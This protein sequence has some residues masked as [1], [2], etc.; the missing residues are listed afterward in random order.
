MAFSPERW[1]SITHG[2]AKGPGAFALRRLLWLGRGP[3]AVGSWIHNRKYAKAANIHRAGVPVISVGNLTVGG[4]GKTPCVEYVAKLLREE[5]LQIAILSRGY[6]SE[7]GRNDEAM[8]LEENLPDVPHLQGADRTELARTAIEELESECL[9]LDDGFQHR[10]LGRDLDIVLIDA[11]DPW[12]GGYLLPR[13]GLREPRS[14]LSRAGFILITRVDQAVDLPKLLEEVA[15]HAPG[16]PVAHSVHRPMEL[17]NGSETRPVEDLAGKT[18]GAFCGIGNPAAFHRTVADLGAA[19]SEL[20]EY[21]DHHPYS[22]ADVEN[23][24]RWAGTL[25]PEAWLVTTQKDW[26]KLRVDALAGRP[27]YAVRI[28]LELTHE[29]ESFDRA[30]RETALQR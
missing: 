8:V 21:P 25:P 9:I 14:R 17:V 22:R 7:I 3:Y 26:V 11:T 29:Q 1:R 12:G 13:G 10:R 19:V 5:D 23:L 28:G 20:K 4:T 30:V 16:K 6:G 15:R 2:T 27:V 24:T 18:V